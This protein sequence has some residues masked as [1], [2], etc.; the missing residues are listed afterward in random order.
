MP[1]SM[2]ISS[3]TGI[4]PMDCT[5]RWGS[6]AFWRTWKLDV[7]IMNLTPPAMSSAP[8]ESWTPRITALGVMRR[9]RS[10]APVMP[11][12]EFPL[13]PKK[14]RWVNLAHMAKSTRLK[15]TRMLLALT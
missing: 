1:P 9:M 5:A 15:M 8:V 6:A 14:K 11:N 13:Y 3:P 12:M 7:P 10:M 4:G 2:P